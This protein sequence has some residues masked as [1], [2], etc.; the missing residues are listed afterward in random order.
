[1]RPWGVC[2][3]V[4]EAFVAGDKQHAFGNSALPEFGVFETAPALLCHADCNVPVKP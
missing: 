4:T 2:E 1:M 3:N